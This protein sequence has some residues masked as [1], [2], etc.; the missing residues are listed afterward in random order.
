MSGEAGLDPRGIGDGV[1]RSENLGPSD[2]QAAKGRNAIAV[3]IAAGDEGTVLGPMAL[4][5][6]RRDRRHE[7]S[8]Q[9]RRSM[10]SATGMSL[11]AVAVEI[12][13]GR[14]GSILE[15]RGARPGDRAAV[16]RHQRFTGRPAEALWFDES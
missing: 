6:S 11:V 10:R 16:L 2:G 12:A 7:T 15:P 5:G 1:R 9:A 4:K 8:A 14:R 13:G 3:E